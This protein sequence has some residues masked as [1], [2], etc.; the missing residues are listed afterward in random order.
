MRLVNFL[1]HGSDTNGFREE[2]ET[3]IECLYANE[4][5]FL[6]VYDVEVGN[7]EGLGVIG[8]KLSVESV[9]SLAT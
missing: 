2:T 9:I 5:G 7:A 6:A 3:A 8:I 1:V 4:L